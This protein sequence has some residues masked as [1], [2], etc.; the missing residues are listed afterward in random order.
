[1]KLYPE[2][3]WVVFGDFLIGRIHSRVLRHIKTVA[4]HSH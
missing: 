1:M 2:A 4:E 3:Y